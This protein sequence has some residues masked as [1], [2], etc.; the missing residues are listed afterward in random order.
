MEQV[1]WWPRRSLGSMLPNMANVSCSTLVIAEIIRRWSW[2]LANMGQGW[3]PAV[4]LRSTVLV[5]IRRVQQ[6]WQ[7]SITV[8]SKSLYFWW[9]ALLIPFADKYKWIIFFALECSSQ[10]PHM[11]WYLTILIV[12]GR[13]NYGNASQY[14]LLPW[15][16]LRTLATLSI[17]FQSS[18]YRWR[19]S[20]RAS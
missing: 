20:V 10:C 2:R 7:S 15:S 5:M 18:I 8:K 16:L 6:R 14:I 4:W 3:Q 17:L 19:D 13:R 11:S 9:L 1:S 12:N